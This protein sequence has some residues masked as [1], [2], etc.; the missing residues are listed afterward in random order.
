MA[1]KKKSEKFDDDIVSNQICS[2]YGDIIEEGSKVLAD[3]ET[4][5]VIGISPNL[6]IALGGGLREGSCVIMTGDPK[7]GKDQPLSA[8]VYTPDGPVKMGSLKIADLV[9][10]PDGIAKV[11]GI[12]PQGLKDVYKVSFNDGTFA[13]CGIDHLWKVCKNY[14]GRNDEWLVLPLSQIIEEGLFS[15]DRPKWKIPMCKPV[16]FNAKNL[17]IDPYILGCLIGD[18]GLLQ[19]TPIITTADD[20]ILQAFK[21]YA[22]S[23]GLEIHHKSRYDYSIVGHANNVNNL[24]NKLRTLNLM[25]KKSSSKFIP[26]HYLYS[27]INHRFE[28]IRGLMDTDGYN[29]KGKSAEY[30]TVSYGLSIHVSELLR[31]LGYMVKTKER[32]TKRNGKEFKSFRLCISGNDINELFKIN[33]KRFSSRQTKSEL[34]KTIRKVELVRKEETQCIFIDHPDHLYLTDSFNVTHNTTTALYFAS[35]AQKVGKKIYYFNTEGRL[36]K[37]NFKGIKGLDI[38]NIKI[39]QPSDK[40]PVVSAEMYLNALEAHIKGTPNF[41]GIVDSVSNMVPQEE[42]EGEIRT[43]VRNALP[44]L[45]SMFLK[46]IS[47]DVARNRAIVIF[48]LHNIANTGGSK[49]SPTKMADSGNMVQ[50]QAGTNM[51]ITHRGKWETDSDQREIGQVANW[52]IK[53]SAA[54]GIPNTTTESWIRYGIGID[55]TKEVAQSAIDFSLIDKAGAWYT[56]K[57][58]IK[59]KTDPI[60]LKVIKDN[61]VEVSDDE[62]VEKLFKFQGMSK[63]S[64]FL[65]KNEKLRDLLYDNVKEILSVK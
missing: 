61:N 19:G 32:T 24:T 48:I 40:T 20:E 29:N 23:N 30:S 16:Y 38:D 5:N 58:A 42:L 49:W 53:T 45:M 54:G 64:D 46:R 28:L 1:A 15:N 26:Q 3:L 36:T 25:G 65:E 51:V 41:V 8:T 50:Y 22:N 55:E 44:R 43:G 17:E 34:F 59:N 62:A 39:V 4:Y 9:C 11:K 12:Y 18:G 47:G 33:R 56:I 10:T 60:V 21:N 35:K 6:D 31:S 13:E 2:K 57:F 14:D 37:E 7:T 27:S 63:L 52:I